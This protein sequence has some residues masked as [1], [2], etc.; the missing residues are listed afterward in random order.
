MKPTST[1]KAVVTKTG[2]LKHGATGISH[3]VHGSAR[4]CNPLRRVYYTTKH[5][6]ATLTF[7]VDA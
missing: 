1:R 6:S 4:W 2:G 5:T 3:I 7:G